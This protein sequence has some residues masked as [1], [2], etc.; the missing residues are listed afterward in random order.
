[1]S[2]PEQELEAELDKIMRVLWRSDL[3]AEAEMFAPAS[4]IVSRGPVFDIKCDACS[5]GPHCDTVLSEAI[6]QA[7]QLARRAA[8]KLDAAIGVEPWQRDEESMKTARLF[9]EIFCHDPSLPIPWADNSPSGATV[10]YRFRAVAREL[11]GGRRIHFVCLPTVSVCTTQSC[12][13]D[14]FARAREGEP[15]VLC[16]NFWQD[17]DIE[18]LPAASFRG[19]ILI[20]EML[21]FLFAAPRGG[22]GGDWGPRRVNPTCYEQFVLRVNGLLALPSSKCKPCR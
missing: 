22:M 21:H 17:P 3:E 2:E 16:D 8:D 4:P 15:I 9:T 1:M 7:I 14:E 5:G 18:G 20:H 10:A 11:D 6:I 13:P 12:C 19:A